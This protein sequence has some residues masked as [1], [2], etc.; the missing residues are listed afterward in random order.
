M[1]G[2]GRWHVRELGALVHVHKYRR[3]VH[4][5]AKAEDFLRKR[6]PK[7]FRRVSGGPTLCKHI[8]PENLPMTAS[9]PLGRLV[10]P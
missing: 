6:N 7:K 5:W 9:R 2:W 8:G 1:N 3:Y 4:E 10:V